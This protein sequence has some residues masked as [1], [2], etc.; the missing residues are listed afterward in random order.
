M[1]GESDMS[2]IL[3]SVSNLQTKCRIIANSH[4]YLLSCSRHIHSSINYRLYYQAPKV[5][6]HYGINQKALYKVTS[7]GY[8]KVFLKEILQSCQSKNN[9]GRKL[10]L[11][12][13]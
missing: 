1:K 2:L 6:S 7:L 13:F 4:K 11:K 9:V 8:Q 5:T 10:H 3:N 12:L